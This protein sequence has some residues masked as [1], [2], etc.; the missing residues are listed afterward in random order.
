MVLPP[1]PRDTKNAA[2]EFSL[3]PSWFLRISMVSE[4]AFRVVLS[5]SSVLATSFDGEDRVV[6]RVSHWRVL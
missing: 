6:L 4:V 1:R 2:E 3:S 5:G